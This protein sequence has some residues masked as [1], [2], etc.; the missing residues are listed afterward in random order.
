MS[1]RDIID[2]Q[3][4]SA[5]NA[6]QDITNLVISSSADCPNVSNCTFNNVRPFLNLSSL[7][8]NVNI[9]IVEADQH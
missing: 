4:P 1:D 6:S 9:S 2:D 3:D 5:S 7:S 8:S